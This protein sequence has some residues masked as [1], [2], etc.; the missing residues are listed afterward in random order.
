M[1]K[2]K[3]HNPTYFVMD[4]WENMPYLTHTLNKL[5]VTGIYKFNAFR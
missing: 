5:Y 2:L 4:N 3:T 1:D